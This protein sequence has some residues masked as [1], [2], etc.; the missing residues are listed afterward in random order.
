MPKAFNTHSA[1]GQVKFIDEPPLR[2]RLVNFGRNGAS[3]LVS[4]AYLNA[5][6]E[7]NGAEI[8]CIG[9]NNANSRLWIASK[10]FDLSYA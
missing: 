1:V 8:A 7:L 4:R 10:S 5:S 2:A 3:Q 6:L 9:D